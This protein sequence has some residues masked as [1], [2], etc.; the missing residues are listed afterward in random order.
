MLG[1]LIKDI[2]ITYGISPKAIADGLCSVPILKKYESGEL[3]LEKLFG[4][5]L[6]Q[7]LGKSMEKYDVIL[8]ADEYDLFLKRS[9]IQELLRIG[10]TKKAEELL[11]EYDTSN[12]TKTRL[13]KQFCALQWAEVLKQKGRSVQEQ[14]ETILRGLKETLKF[15]E[16][17]PEIMRKHRFGMLE[18]L[19]LERYAISCELKGKDEVAERWYIEVMAYLDQ[20]GKGFVEYDLADKYRIYPLM[21]YH[22][23]FLYVKKRKYD[24]AL[25]LLEEGCKMLGERFEQPQLFVQMQEMKQQAFILAGQNVPKEEIRYL[26]VMKEILEEYAPKKGC[27]YPMYCEMYVHSVNDTVRERRI[28]QGSSEEDL[29]DDVCD[30]RTVHRIESR[31]SRAQNRVR[32][33]LLEKVGLEDRRYDGDLVT[34]HYD[35]YKVLV[36]MSQNIYEHNIVGAREKYK[37]LVNRLDTRRMTNYQFA[38]YWKL[39]LDKC[40]NIISETETKCQLWEFLKYTLPGK[41]LYCKG[42]CILHYY[43]RM[44]LVSLVWDIQGEMRDDLLVVLQ[45]QYERICKE[46]G[47]RNSYSDYYVDVMYSLSRIYRDLCDYT[48]AEN[49]VNKVLREMFG[50]GRFAQWERLMFMKFLIMERKNATVEIGSETNKQLL[51]YGKYAYVLAR[52][53]RQENLITQFIESKLVAKFSKNIDEILLLE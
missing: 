12:T 15:K 7:R 40:D 22:L 34:R 2:R 46:N 21:A 23:A 19:L 32:K 9:Y 8:D 4:D 50:M 35:D 41:D 16:L 20:K 13:H 37:V 44:I 17:K 28:E 52:Y 18:L 30:V 27:T 33:E 42:N 26:E 38:K 24:E 47:L 31:K 36:E 5:A 1:E 25:D 51:R 10:E 11:N 3:R 49:V 48:I 29:A 43:E 45:A 6:L 39:I 53:Y 14:E